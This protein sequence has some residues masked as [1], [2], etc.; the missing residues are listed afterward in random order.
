[1]AEESGTQGATGS[2]YP[3]FK[4]EG[5]A[6]D[7][8][9]FEEDFKKNKGGNLDQE[10]V[11]KMSSADSA[12]TAA[13]FFYTISFNKN[14]RE[15]DPEFSNN[16]IFY[17]E[18]YSQSDEDKNLI[19]KNIDEGKSVDGKDIFEMSKKSANQKYNNA[20]ILKTGKVTKIIETIGSIDEIEKFEKYNSVKSDFDSKI[21][22][23]KIKFDSILDRFFDFLYLFNQPGA[24]EAG[25][26]N[27][28]KYYTPEN[29]AMISAF[30]KILEAE[31]FNS[32][33]V[34][35]MSKKYDENIN[36]LIESRGG[37]KAEDVIKEAGEEA[38]KE[39][40]AKTEEQKL[41]DKS[42]AST[43]GP[44]GPVGP[45]ESTT[46]I[47][48]TP[49]ST[50]GATTTTTTETLTTTTTTTTPSTTGPT[51]SDKVEGAKTTETKSATG[52]TGAKSEAEKR[53]EELLTSTL[54]VKFSESGGTGDKKGTGGT[55][56]KSEVEKRQEELLSSLLGIKFPE[57]GS[58][59]ATG[60]T[61]TKTST[62]PK[63][64]NKETK[65]EEKIS[66]ENVKSPETSTT[67]T[68][69]K[70][71]TTQNLSS[72]VTPEA[73]K[74][75]STENK[76]ESGATTNTTT[77]TNTQTETN[78]ETTPGN[79]TEGNTTSNIK[80]EESE[81]EKMEL[82][83]EMNDNIKSMVSLLNQL[84]STLQNPL[85]VIPND[86]KFN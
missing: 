30:A 49:T 73:P 54:G 81:K 66:P 82:N 85:I 26:A 44:T 2:E 6:F 24:D 1:L 23:E 68:P 15:L 55:G 21:K 36:K 62:T 32:P 43:T 42:I 29:N 72:P 75:E 37:K 20:N 58:T 46:P 57:P 35:E 83:K 59:G 10:E 41:E 52:G 60:T 84:N 9:K 47:T 8:I 28:S 7:R 14:L 50:T 34:L 5:G 39:A 78:T 17:R 76:T 74:N 69:I 33:D 86:K 18:A 25:A 77:T 56:A 19:S 61:G 70:E 65:L 53:Q 40:T 63:T 38:K 12:G 79:T 48:V 80:N 64:E 51:G 67:S 31:G 11:K 3:V 71:T 4:S 13:K 16:L 45:V 27:A 22:D